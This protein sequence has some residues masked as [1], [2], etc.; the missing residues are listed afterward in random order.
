M[1]TCISRVSG[2]VYVYQETEWP[3]IRVS[4]L[5]VLNPFL[6]FSDCQTPDSFRI[7]FEHGSSPCNCSDAVVL[8]IILSP[9][10]PVF[11]YNSDR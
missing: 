3:C 7:R 2:H 11:S 1:Y 5:S 9:K 8:F 4:R 10:V 6:R